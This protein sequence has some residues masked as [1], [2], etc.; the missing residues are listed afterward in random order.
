MTRCHVGESL[1]PKTNLIVIEGS[2]NSL[3]RVSIMRIH[4]EGFLEGNTSYRCTASPRSIRWLSLPRALTMQSW[5]KCY[6]SGLHGDNNTRK[7]CR[8]LKRSAA[9][10]SSV[11][12][13]VDG[14]NQILYGER[15]Y[16]RQRKP[17]LR[18]PSFFPPHISPYS[19]STPITRFLFPRIL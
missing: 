13:L 12:A 15:N 6:D 17:D 3:H 5:S 19:S 10:L 8:W 18:C 1:F 2:T 14:E 11:T 16:A 9:A 7:V 4:Q